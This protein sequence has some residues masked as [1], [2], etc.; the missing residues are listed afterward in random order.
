[1]TNPKNPTRLIFGTFSLLLASGMLYISCTQSKPAEKPSEA[2]NISKEMVS[3][4]N[5]ANDP[6]SFEIKDQTLFISVKKG[7]DFFNNPEDSSV[8]ATAPLLY[9]KITGDFVVKALVQPDFNAQ[10]NAVSLMAHFD[11]L[12]W[13][14][15]AFENSDATGPGIVSV[16]TNGVSDDANGVVL[17]EHK[18]VWLALV[19]KK[20]NYSM[21]WSL[22]GQ[23]YTM[24]RLT[25]LPD[26]GEIKIGIEAQ[27][28]VGESATHQ[29]HFFEIAERTVEDLR[30]L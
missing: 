17:N 28:P 22:D 19:R 27:S 11:S 10:W 20:N 6:N 16:V 25:S 23:R 9:Q 30:Q 4:M 24:A 26:L 13:I 14:K 12:H 8:T 5:W 29:V 7:S 1:M 15:F 2:G 3:D 21:H 18:K